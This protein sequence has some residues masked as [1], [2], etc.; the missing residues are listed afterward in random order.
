MNIHFRLTVMNF[1][2]FFVWGAW[3]ISFGAYMSKSLGFTGIEIGSIYGT[4]G[5]AS[6][7]MPGLLGIVADRWV[8][9]ERLYGILHLTGAGLLVW[10]STVRDYKTLYVIMLLNSMVYMPTIALNNS[11]SFRVLEQQGM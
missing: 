6:L 7:F 1:M 2:Q 9:A 3:L 11:I 4:M 10:A 5:V 8:N